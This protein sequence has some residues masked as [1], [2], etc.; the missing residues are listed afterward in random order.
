MMRLAVYPGSFDPV[1]RGHL[2]LIERA[3]GL[4]DRVI[5]AVSNNAAKKHLFSL[6]ERMRM[7]EESL[8][9]SPQVEVDTFSGLLVDYLKSRKAH[10]ILRGLRAVSDMDSEFQMASM[11]RRLYPKAETVFLMPEEKYTYLSSSTVREVALMGGALTPFV[12]PP[13]LKRLRSKFERSR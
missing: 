7:I 1:T 13:V 9:R 6:E 8:R 5:V 3:C 10:I 12:T 2:D 11:N 4:F